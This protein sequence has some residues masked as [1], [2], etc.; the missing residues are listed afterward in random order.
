MTI[1]SGADGC[2][3]GWVVIT[4]NLCDGTISCRLAKGAQELFYPEMPP[5][6]IAV[7]IP[8]G[9]PNLGSRA[10]DQEARQL[11]GPGRASSVFPAPIRPV[12]RACSYKE[13]CDVRSSEEG[14][15]MSRQAWAIV[16]KVREVDTLFRQNPDLQCRVREVHPEVSF[17]YLNGERP[18]KYSKKRP[19]GKKERLALLQPVCCRAFEDALEGLRNL[20]RD[21]NRDLDDKSKL[22]IGS[23]DVLDAFAAL[24][25]AQ[26]IANSEAKTIPCVRETDCYGLTM[27]IVA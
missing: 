10:C 18:M 15:R 19:E 26:R 3:G 22:R 24:W 25:T 7:D 2:K 8:I 27:E 9:L 4:K 5:Q 20:A 16:N 6:V 13:A 23:D 21:A 14:K 11:L 12:L 17:Y 1:V